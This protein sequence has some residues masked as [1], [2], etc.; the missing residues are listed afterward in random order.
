M[1]RMEAANWNLDTPFKLV[2]TMDGT[3]KGNGQNI[4]VAGLK[5][6]KF[7]SQNAVLGDA[8]NGKFIPRN[9]TAL[10]S[11]LW[12]PKTRIIHWSILIIFS[13]L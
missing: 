4:I 3:L 5:M 11:E 2:A 9:V 1:T 10:W 7:E 12:F 13:K 8:F 6:A